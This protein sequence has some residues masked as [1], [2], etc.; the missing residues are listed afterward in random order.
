MKPPEPTPSQGTSHRVLDIKAE[1]LLAIVSPLILVVSL[2][3]TLMAEEGVVYIFSCN[4]LMCHS[5]CSAS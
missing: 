3:F 2:T 5:P 1:P 4:N